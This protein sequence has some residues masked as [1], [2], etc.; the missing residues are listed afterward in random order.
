MNVIA[1][2]SFESSTEN[3]NT[4]TH[5]HQHNEAVCMYVVSFGSE[6]S[7]VNIGSNIKATK[8]H[9]KRKSHYKMKNK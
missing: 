8:L 9:I 3:K 1:L 5:S 6:G 4:S 2:T 7:E